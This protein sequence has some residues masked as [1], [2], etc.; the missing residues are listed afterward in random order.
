MSRGV[1]E[2]TTV[3]YL[4]EIAAPAGKVFDFVVDVR[5]EPQWNPQMLQ[6]GMLTAEPIGVGTRFV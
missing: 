4:I 2:E 1:L 3:E 6:V 5:N